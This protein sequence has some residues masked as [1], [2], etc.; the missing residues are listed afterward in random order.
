VL[1]ILGVNNALAL[2]ILAGI[3]EFLPVVGPLL[4]AVAAVLVALF[5]GTNSWGL[6]PLVF[7]G[8]VLAAMILIQQIENYLLVPRIVGDSLELHPLV[9]MISVLMGTSLAGLLGAVLAAPVVATIKLLGTYLWRK[10][11]DLPPFPVAQELSAGRRRGRRRRS[12]AEA[13]PTGGQMVQ[14]VRAWFG[15]K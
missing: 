1:A 13:A 14:R 5:Q 6:S 12:Q 9:V 11:L 3:L 7:A 2:G 4:S 10:L 15:Y 8:V